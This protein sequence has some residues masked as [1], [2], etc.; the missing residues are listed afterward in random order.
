LPSLPGENNVKWRMK[1]VVR[2]KMPKNE[3]E[4]EAEKLESSEKHCDMLEKSNG[5][6]QLEAENL[7]QKIALKDHELLEKHTEIETANSDAPRAF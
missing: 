1:F 7:V 3:I 6:L 5:N 4:K 2:K